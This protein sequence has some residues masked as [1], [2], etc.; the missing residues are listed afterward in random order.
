[1]IFESHNRRK[2]SK[3]C[4]QEWIGQEGSGNRRINAVQ[5]VSYFIS[6]M[7][8]QE[9]TGKKSFYFSSTSEALLFAVVAYLFPD[10]RATRFII[11]RDE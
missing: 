2:Y 4:I 1:M 6:I 11:Q 5:N 3:Y 9:I 10:S 7:P 8:R